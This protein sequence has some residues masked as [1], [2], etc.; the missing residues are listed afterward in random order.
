[1]KEK[2]FS[3]VVVIGGGASG[4]LAAIF[5]SKKNKK[6]TILEAQSKVGKKILVTGNGKC[7]LLNKNIKLENYNYDA[8][9]FLS[10][11]LNKYSYDKVVKFFLSLGLLTKVDSMGRIYP[12]CEQAS[13][14]LDIL[15]MECKKLNVREICDFS[16]LNISKLKNKFIIESESQEFVSSKLIIS[17]G[18]AASFNEKNFYILKKILESM[19]HTYKKVFPSL[20]PL[21]TNSGFEKYL[22]GIRAPAT[23]KLVADDDLVKE[24]SGEIQFTDKGISGICIF[25]LSRL[26][27]EFLNLGTIE[28]KFKSNVH[29]LVDLLPKLS[30]EKVIDIINSRV[31]NF[32][33]LSIEFLFSGII[34]K[35][36]LIPILKHLNIDYKNR[37]LSFLS[38]KE[39]ISICKVI[40]NF[41]FVPVDTL[42]FKNAQ[43]MSGGIN[44]N[45]INN[46]TLE[47]LKIKNLFFTGE[48]L[49]IDGECGGYNL[50]WAFIS[51]MAAGEA[52]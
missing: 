15:R 48:I 17:T 45:E 26:V 27:S 47:S 28:G 3:D 44:L 10:P 36:F 38:K 13:S 22:K 43:V 1:M 7:N 50:Y 14:V 42:Q 6:V 34:N 12:I 33:D 16:V 49:N 20:V 19:G 21:K 41:K 52:V 37:N 9:K 51:G 2:I 5:A 46:K 40:K 4:L 11:F 39:I 18:G 24:E 32:N 31:K 8:R 23:V 35:K 30:L 25:Q 29:I